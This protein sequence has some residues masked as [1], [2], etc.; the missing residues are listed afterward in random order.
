MSKIDKV[1]ELL[2]SYCAGGYSGGFYGEANARW[3]E[4]NFGEL[5]RVY[6][7]YRLGPAACL[8]RDVEEDTPRLDELIEVL[9]GLEDYPL[10]D[11]S[12]LSDLIVKDEERVVGELATEWEV[13]PAI[14]WEAIQE[15]D[16]TLDWEQDYVYLASCYEDEVKAKALELN[17]AE[18]KA[19]QT[20]ETHYFAGQNHTVEV[21]EYC[22][23][24]KEVA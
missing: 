6:D 15:C 21:C 14:V 20:W 1:Q 22:I 17:V 10:I 7:I 2:G 23:E 24:A 13:P 5:A 16:V 9:E 8:L 3:V 19:M 4:D 18:L 12:Y 11:D